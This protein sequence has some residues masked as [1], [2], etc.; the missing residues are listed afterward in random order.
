MPEIPELE[1]VCEVLQKNIAGDTITGI[2]VVRPG[3]PIIVRDFT[4]AGFETTLGGTTIEKVSRRGKYLIFSIVSEPSGLR[5][6]LNPKLSGLLQL[7]KTG[8]RYKPNTHVVLTLSGNKELRYIDQKR[9]GQMYLAY[10]FDLIPDFNDMGPEPFDI[11]LDEFRKRLKS[12]RGEIKG[13]LTRGRFVAGIGN[14]YADE[15]LWE[16]RIHPYTKVSRLTSGDVERLFNAMRRTLSAAI[17]KVRIE[18]SDGIDKKPRDFLSI[19]MKTGEPCPRCG[20]P[21]SLVG[22]NQR[23]TNFCRKCQPGGLIKGM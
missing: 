14:A 16:G 5:L 12:N 3:G 1:V 15:I 7:A 19:H 23:I 22:A 21:I 10:D 2:E 11:S 13:V 4:H 18:M 17:E 9:M 8:D 20:T 6:V